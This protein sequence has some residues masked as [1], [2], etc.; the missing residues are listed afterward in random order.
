[1]KGECPMGRYQI[2]C[3]VKR[4]NHYDPHERIESIGNQAGRWMI[5]E[6]SGIRRIES[7]TDSF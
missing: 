7:G 2:T 4:G 1:M 5:T 3:I 6:D